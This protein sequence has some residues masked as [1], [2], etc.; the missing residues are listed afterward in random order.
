FTVFRIPLAQIDD[1][2]HFVDRANA[3]AA[4]PHRNDVTLVSGEFGLF[5]GDTSTIQCINAAQ[6]STLA[7]VGRTF[8]VLDFPACP[9][10]FLRTGPGHRL[11]DFLDD[12][13]NGFAG[14]MIYDVSHGNSDAI[15]ATSSAAGAFPNLTSDDL[16]G[17]RTGVFN[18]FVSIS[19]DNDA[20]QG[21]RNFAMGMYQHDSIAVVS[22]TQSVF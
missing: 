17:L 10:D 21:R 6:L 12:P 11:A 18:V 2:R 1:L 16:D 13:S 14:G 4:A 15:F 8:M 19:C 22:A 5:A 3:F 9:P 7:S 20:P